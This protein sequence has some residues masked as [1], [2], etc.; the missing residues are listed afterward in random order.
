MSSGGHGGQL[1]AATSLI[2]CPLADRLDW[3]PLSS[4]MV[5]IPPPP[6]SQRARLATTRLL[7]CTRSLVTV[8]AALVF[9]ADGLSLVEKGSMCLLA[10]LARRGV[11]VRFSSGNLPAQ[12]DANPVLKSWLRVVLRSAHVVVSQGPVWTRYF[13]S[14]SEAV[15]KVVEIPN[16]VALQPVHPPAQ[17]PRVAF[18]GWMHREKGI[19]ELLDAAISLRHQFPDV[20]FDFIGGGRDMSALKAEV[21]EKE[22]ERWVRVDGWLDHEVTLARLATASVFALPSYYEGLPNAM[23]EAMAAGLPI[24]ATPVGAIPDVVRDGENGLLV[25]IG[26]ANA[27]TAA[28]RTLLE[29]PARAREMGLR[30]RA[31]IAQQHDVERVWRDYGAAL[32]RACHEAGRRVTIAA[33]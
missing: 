32:E 22:L 10:R 26:D 3:V 8:D 11:V 4:T 14:F 15:G 5:S 2:E 25:P 29:N 31:T 6:L 24:V 27:L 21:A 16:G 1:T 13:G 30:G 7:S 33:D 9:V 28:L 23:L 20:E 12:C 19:F 18:V 17:K